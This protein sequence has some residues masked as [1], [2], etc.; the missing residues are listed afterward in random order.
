MRAI[1]TWYNG[2]LFRSRTEAKWAKLFDILNIK[3]DYEIEGFVMNDGTWY[4][5]DFFL[6]SFEDGMY[7]EVKGEFTVEEKELCRNFC[8]ESGFKVLLAEGVPNYREYQFLVKNS[9]GGV[10]YFLGLPNA[11]R[12]E[13]E[14]RMFAESGLSDF[15]TFAIPNHNLDQLNLEYIQAIKDAKNARFEHGEKG[16]YPKQP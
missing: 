12:A 14:N 13:Y 1:Q 6:P 15:F 7:V 4:L 9:M 2:V 16:T 11:N 5:P 8:E 10:D 3:W